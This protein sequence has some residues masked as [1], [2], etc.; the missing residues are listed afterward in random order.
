DNR[1]IVSLT[2]NVGFF[3]SMAISTGFGVLVP[4]GTFEYVHEFEN[5]QHSLG[6]SFVYAPT[7][8]RF[9]Y[10]TDFPDRDF[11]N[12]GLGT[13]LFLPDVKSVFVSVRELLGSN[14]RTA[15]T[16][17]AGIRLPF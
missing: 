5:D 4:Q 12:L 7:R 8:P 9:L 11:F 3:A 14:T 16:V 13:V 17:T 2:T 1:N 15:T 6:F 10:Q